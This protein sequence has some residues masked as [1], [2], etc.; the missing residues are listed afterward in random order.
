MNSAMITKLLTSQE[1][2][3]P[4]IMGLQVEECSIN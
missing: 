3:Q 2:K 1:E 4:D